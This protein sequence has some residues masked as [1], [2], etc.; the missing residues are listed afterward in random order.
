MSGIRRDLQSA[1]HILLYGITSHA[2]HVLAHKSRPHTK[3]VLSMGNR[4][5]SNDKVS[6]AVLICKR[7][8]QFSKQTSPPFFSFLGCARPVSFY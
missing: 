3:R 2:S 6:N 8:T 4:I 7:M 1:D 5:P